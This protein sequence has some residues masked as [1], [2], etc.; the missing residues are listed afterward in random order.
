[1]SCIKESNIPLAHEFYSPSRFQI[2]FKERL[3]FNQIEDNPTL[4]NEDSCKTNKIIDIKNKI[5]GFCRQRSPLERFVFFV[6][7]AYLIYYIGSKNKTKD[8]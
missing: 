3:Q 5:E 7:I 8:N 1:M 6:L 2:D 4:K